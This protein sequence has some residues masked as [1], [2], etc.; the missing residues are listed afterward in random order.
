M[1]KA[2]CHTLNKQTRTEFPK[3]ND[4]TNQQTYFKN[5]NHLKNK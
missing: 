1:N 3:F 5:D 2:Y 4:N